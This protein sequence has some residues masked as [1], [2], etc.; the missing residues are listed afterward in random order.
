MPTSASRHDGDRSTASCEPLTELNG[1]IARR[2]RRGPGRPARSPRPAA[3]EP[4]AKSCRS[5]CTAATTARSPSTRAAASRCSI[6]QPR[7]ARLRRRRPR[8]A[9]TRSSAR[10]ASSARA[11]ST[12]RPARRWPGAAGTVLVTGGVRADL[13]PELAADAHRRRHPADRLAARRRPAAGPARSA[14]PRCCPALADQL[15]ELAGLASFALNAA[16]NAAVPYPPPGKL[17]GNA[18]GLRRLG[19]GR[20]QRHGL[21]G[22]HR[23]EQR[24]HG[25][26]AR[27]RR[28]AATPAALVAQIKAGLGGL[29]SAEPRRDRALQ[30]TL[31]D[32]ARAWPSSEGDSADRGDGHRRAQRGLRLRPLFRPQRPAGRERRTPDRPRRPP[33]TS[34]RTAPAVAIALDVDAGPAAGRDRWAAPATTGRPRRSQP[35]SSAA[36]HGGPRRMPAGSPALGRLRRRDR[37]GERGGAAQAKNAQANDRALADDLSSRRA[38]L[39]RQSRRGAAR[40]V[41]YQQA[42]SVS[43]R[44]VSITNELFDD[45]LQIGR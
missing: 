3:G 45:L 18:D 11:R 39:G 21:P 25:G 10:S 20:P 12:P 16:H 28:A 36:R 8:S 40:L 17:L 33:A 5:P 24:R 38:G 30:I 7:A 42:Y 2:R 23:P 43:A 44:L 41:L 4:R 27:H 37:R 15:G 29:G 6:A 13:T 22:R 34:R 32:R 19:S 35:P 1:Q 14:R 26:H 31:N 9:P